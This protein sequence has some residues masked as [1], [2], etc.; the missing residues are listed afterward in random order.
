MR[1]KLSGD[2]M[3]RKLT[4][5]IIFLSCLTVFSVFHSGCMK[6]NKKGNYESPGVY[7]NWPQVKF[8]DTRVLLATDM[9]LATRGFA[10]A[11][12]GDFEKTLIIFPN[13]SEGAMFVNMDQGYGEVKRDLKIVFLDSKMNVLKEDIMK[14]GDGFSIAPPKTA[15]AIEGL[16]PVP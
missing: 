11:S 2:K 12:Y 1:I 6:D 10:V 4:A 3:G 8:K 15:F 14:K 5:A 16:P 13:I 9:E 7:E